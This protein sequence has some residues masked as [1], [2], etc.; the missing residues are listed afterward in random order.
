MRILTAMRTVNVSSTPTPRENVNVNQG[1][2]ETAEFAS[3]FLL[4]VIY[5]L[6]SK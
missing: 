5:H 6:K 1:F 2:K 3:S 4:K